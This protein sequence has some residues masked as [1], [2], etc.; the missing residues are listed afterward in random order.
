MKMKMIFLVMFVMFATS[1]LA[2][3]FAYTDVV[4]LNQDPDPAEPGDTLELRWKVSKKG[5]AEI[6]NLS[7]K[8]DPDYPFSLDPSSKRIKNVGSWKGNSYSDEYYMLHYKLRVADDAAEDTYEIPLMEKHTLNE[9]WSSKKYDV[10]VGESNDVDLVLGSV[11]SSPKKLVP[12]T[13]E[14][15]LNVNLENIGQ[16]DAK[17]VRTEL[18]LPDGF[19]SSHSFSDESNIGTV[20]AGKGQRAEFYVDLD[21]DL[22]GGEH[23]AELKVKYKEKE[24]SGYAYKEI[25]LPF[26][27]KV[28]KRPRFEIVSVETSPEKIT[29]ED[30][31]MLKFRVRNTG[32]EDA[33]SLSLRAFKESSQPFEFDEKYD[34]I[35]DLDEGK[36][37]EAVISLTVDK[38]A[39]PKEY[40]LDLETRSV[41]GD[42]VLVENEK[43]SITI[44]ETEG[45]SQDMTMIYYL[46]VAIVTLGIGVLIGRRKK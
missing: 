42:E 35:G 38:D 33:E 4:M 20:Y 17:N 18:V 9:S 10:R 29:A 30:S 8:L 6:E 22:N 28:M 1:A 13:D 41:Y 36:T 14:V 32:G 5:N 12:G 40:L 37:G 2:V 46:V 25:T 44:E 16:E 7:Y 3:D 19:G 23:E 21:E 15:S 31:V 24:T 43:A 11:V 45:R 26:T 34:Y 27:I 39:M